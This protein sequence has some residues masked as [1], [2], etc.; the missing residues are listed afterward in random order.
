MR[1]LLAAI[2]LALV[3]AACHRVPDSVI[4]PDDMAELMADVRVA[5]AVIAVNPSQYNAPGTREALR[6][7]VFARHGVT[8]E[9]F[10]SSLVWYGHNI[11]VYQDV[12]DRSI[13]ILEARLE[14]VNGVVAEAALS[15]AGDSVDVWQRPSALTVNSF[16]PSQYI[17]F[18][19][20]ADRNWERGD[21]FTWNARLAVPPVSAT[22]SMT[23]EYS[24][25]TIETVISS[26]DVTELNRQSIT[27]FT[28][29]TRTAVA[30]S[31]WLYLGMEGR[32]P[33][34]VDSISLTRSRITMPNHPYRRMQRRLVPRL[35]PN[36]STRTL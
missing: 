36:D 14:R 8:K 18:N 26:L 34:V 11:G 29:T 13:E 1:K 20:S 24:D 33:V 30:L 27:F 32:R 15:V 7:A 31:G 6:D 9:Q 2:A 3:A 28:D 23:A 22:W 12:T 16:S 5:D 4:Q 25:G 17:T 21:F 10:D 19:L 35:D